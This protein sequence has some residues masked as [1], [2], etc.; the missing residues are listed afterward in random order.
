MAPRDGFEPST[1]ALTER[2]ST[3]ELPGTVPATQDELAGMAGEPAL[4]SEGV[5]GGTALAIATLKR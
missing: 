1:F 4:A 5:A 3:V 2:R